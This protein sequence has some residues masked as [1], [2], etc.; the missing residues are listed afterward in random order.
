MPEYIEDDEET[1]GK[2]I[3]SLKKDWLTRTFE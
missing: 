1:Y 2:L 3:M